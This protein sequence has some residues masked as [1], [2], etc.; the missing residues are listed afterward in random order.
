[1]SGSD[2]TTS[3]LTKL[4]EQVLSGDRPELAKLAA[5]GVLPIPPADLVWLQVALAEGT[6]GKVAAMAAEA[7]QAMEPR[8]LAEVVGEGLD[9]R[10]LP[11]LVEHVDHPLI[12]DATLRRSDVPRS[13]LETMAPGLSADLQETLLLRQDAI[14]ERPEILEALESNPDLS[15][16]SRR[17]VTEY[18]RHLLPTKS[19]PEPA[20]PAAHLTDEEIESYADEEMEEAIEEAKEVGATGE[21]DEITGLTE[22]QL[23]TLP[24]PARLKLSR[25]APKALRSILIRD[26]SSSVA[27]SVLENNPM[28]DSEV[29]QIAGNRAVVDE[30]L[31]AIARNRNWVRRPKIALALV[32][33]PRTA[34]GV[35]IR[36][37]PQLS[38]RALR[39]ISRDRNVASSVRAAAERLYRLKL[40]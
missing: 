37:A 3:L 31:S 32:K 17:L 40:S 9:V 6:G 26:I 2:E 18:R 29:E 5:E 7:L 39:S 11:W 23:R 36:L 25:R 38:V 27:V 34:A 19:G 12:L 14:V 24:L 15:S 13:L 21:R 30:V 22:S 10:S 4:V 8:R 28:S 20:E 35:A 16:H 1:M 33:N